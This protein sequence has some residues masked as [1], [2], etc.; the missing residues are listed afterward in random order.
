M[1]LLYM[2]HI[3]TEIVYIGYDEDSYIAMCCKLLKT[4]LLL[5]LMYLYTR[6]LLHTTFKLYN[7]MKS[8]SNYKLDR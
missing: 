2:L 8:I 1:A 5:A 4:F 6:I 3:I 7:F